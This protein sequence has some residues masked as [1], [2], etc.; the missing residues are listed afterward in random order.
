MGRRLLRTNEK[1]GVNKKLFN[2]Q[3]RGKMEILING[4]ALH[5]PLADRSVQ[6]CVTSPPYFL[7]HHRIVV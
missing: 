2:L 4:N 3:K 7:T 6:C 1:P 5:I